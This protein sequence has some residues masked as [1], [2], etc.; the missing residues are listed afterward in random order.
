MGLNKNMFWLWDG[1]AKY[2]DKWEDMQGSVGPLEMVNSE[3]E[4]ILL[5]MKILSE[6][7]VDCADQSSIWQELIPDGEHRYISKLRWDLPPC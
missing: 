4:A 6:G 7:I 3:E 1:R 5:G 2:S